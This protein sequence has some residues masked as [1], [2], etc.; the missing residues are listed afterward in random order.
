MFNLR[1]YLYKSSSEIN[2]QIKG[3]IFDFKF[4]N[5]ISSAVLSGSM[6]VSVSVVLK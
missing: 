3:K 6:I 1:R 2:S 4:G 5:N